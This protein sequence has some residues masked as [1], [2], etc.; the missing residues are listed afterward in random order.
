MPRLRNQK[1]LP[2]KVTSFLI[3]QKVEE[4][5]Y[6]RQIAPVICIYPVISIAQL[7]PALKESN[8]LSK[9]WP[10]KSLLMVEV[11]NVFKV[12]HMLRKCVLQKKT[13]Y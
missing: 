11:E 7:E 9:I 6:K 3:K 2:Q 1:L 13:Q 12:K 5:A 4:L 8:P 10:K